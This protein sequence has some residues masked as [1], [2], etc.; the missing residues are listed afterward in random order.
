MQGLNNLLADLILA[1]K[2]PATNSIFEKGHAT[3]HTCSSCERYKG[4]ST[5]GVKVIY[6]GD[7]SY[8]K[9]SSL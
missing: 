1:V 5:T 4:K 8:P 3:Y 9:I 7:G 2:I 6:H